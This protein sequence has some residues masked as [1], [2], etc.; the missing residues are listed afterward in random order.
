M[1]TEK[2]T[3]LFDGEC[4][5]CNFW[6]GLIQK[7]KVQHKFNYYPLNSPEG[8]ELL[9]SYKV[10][11]SIDSIIVIA[12]DKVFSKTGAGFKIARTLGGLWNL[13]LILW[14]IP[15]PIRNWF[16]DFLAKN[17]SKFFKNIE[18]CEIHN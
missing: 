11:S 2:T 12:N 14:L 6:V 5:F 7:Q 18:N 13:T 15:R 9:K 10:D 3:L 17:R 16:Y 1:K 4:K 8:K